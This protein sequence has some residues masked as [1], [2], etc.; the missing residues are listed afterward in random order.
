MKLENLGLFKISLKE[1]K[2]KTPSDLQDGQF[3]AASEFPGVCYSPQEVLLVFLQTGLGQNSPLW[4][5]WPALWGFMMCLK[6]GQR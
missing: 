3:A 6:T 4:I 5:R 1:V 2:P